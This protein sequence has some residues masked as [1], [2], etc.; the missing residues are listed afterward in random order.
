MDNLG[1]HM[2]IAG[3]LPNALHRGREVGCAVVQI[4]L[5]N[6]MQ[7]AGRAVAAEEVAE[8]KRVKDATGIAPVFAHATYLINL[9]APDEME[10]RRALDAFHDELERAEA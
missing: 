8:F 3:G 9:A 10:W 1:A 4:F 5:K 6:Q 7:W 2:S